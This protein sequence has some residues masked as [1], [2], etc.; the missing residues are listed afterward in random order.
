[1]RLTL[2]ATE[3]PFEGGVLNGPILAIK[4]LPRLKGGFQFENLA[5]KTKFTLPAEGEW[6]T[7][8]TLEE[9]VDGQ[10]LIVDWITFPEPSIF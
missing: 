5:R 10:W 1:M 9:K 8:M 6:Y 4:S 2:T 3:T 7:V